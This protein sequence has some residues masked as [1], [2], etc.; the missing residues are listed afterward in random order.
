VP[1]A[2]L[3]VDKGE[4]QLEELVEQVVLAGAE[5]DGVEAGVAD[6]AFDGLA[7]GLVGGVAR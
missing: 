1:A 7:V 2:A 3:A 6:E 5:V 4:P